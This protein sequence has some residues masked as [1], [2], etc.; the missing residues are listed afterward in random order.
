MLQENLHQ[1]PP[2]PP[3]RINDNTEF[4]S[5]PSKGEIKT[6]PPVPKPRNTAPKM[7]QAI[8]SRP[9]Q[10]DQSDASLHVVI[11]ENISLPPEINS[12]PV[13]PDPPPA[14]S[15]AGDPPPAASTSSQDMKEMKEDMKDMKEDMKEM[16]QTINEMIK[17]QTIMLQ[18]V[19]ALVQKLIPQQ[20]QGPELILPAEQ[21]NGA[22]IYCIY[23]M[24][25]YCSRK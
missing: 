14:P 16:L 9:T 15:T 23:K 12:K 11:H 17:Q 10:P 8:P 7:Q 4:P 22:N 2:T 3:P 5:L 19:I 13:P 25:C 18:T 1:R 21:A 24:Y 6:S 20:Q